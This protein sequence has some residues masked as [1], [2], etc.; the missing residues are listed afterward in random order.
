MDNFIAL[1]QV[2]IVQLNNTYEVLLVSLENIDT[3]YRYEQ[4]EILGLY[5]YADSVLG[6]PTQKIAL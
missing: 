3:W 1:V 2:Q 6:M 4:N 5:Y